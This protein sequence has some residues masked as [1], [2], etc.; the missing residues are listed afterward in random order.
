MSQT[1]AFLGLRT[2]RQRPTPLRLPW[3]SKIPC[4]LR[5]TTAWFVTVSLANLDWL[6]GNHI[7]V[8]CRRE[9]RGISHVKMDQIGEVPRC[10]IGN[11]F[12][13]IKKS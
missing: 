11:E 13:F 1:L 3:Q 10:W 8:K 2:L 12:R 4:G 6:Q 9:E 5:S 7:E